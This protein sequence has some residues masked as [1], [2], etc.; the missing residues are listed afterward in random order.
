MF[1]KVRP[2]LDLVTSKQSEHEVG[3]Q[4]VI[5]EVAGRGKRLVS[6]KYFQSA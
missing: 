3:G 5:V 1:S 2:T 4:T 6:Q